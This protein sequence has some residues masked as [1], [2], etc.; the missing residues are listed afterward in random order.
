MEKKNIHLENHISSKCSS[1][2]F[3]QALTTVYKEYYMNGAFYNHQANLFINSL[4]E[5]ESIN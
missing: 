2:E 4:N 1:D 3:K 5:H